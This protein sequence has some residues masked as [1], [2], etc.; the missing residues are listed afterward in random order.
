MSLNTNFNVNPYYD[1]FDEDKK[2][3][4]L[5]FK[6]GYAVQARELTQLQTLLQNQTSRFGNHIFRNGSLVTGGQTFIQ[7]ATYL[8]LNSDYANTAISVSN[9]NGL[10][11][12]N[13]DGSKRGEVIAVYDADAGTGDPKTLLVK[14]IY[15]NTFTSGETIQTIQDA[16][17]YANISTSGVGTGQTF[18]I[19]EGV[20]YYDGY[21]IKNSA[22]TIATSKYDNT[23][24][25]ARIGFEITESIVVSSQDTSLLDPAQDA[26]NYQAPGADRYKVDLIL[27]TRS[28]TSTDTSQFIELAQ[29]ENGVLVSANKYPLYA[30][31]EDTFARRTY[32]ESGNY[33]VRPFQLS[34][35]TSAA[36]SAKANVIM[37]PGK[38]Y[39]YGYE[40][41][42]IAPTTI[43]FDKPRTTDNV[44]GKRIS[45]DYG[46]YVYA[47][48][49]NGSLP[50]D[51][52][53]TVDLHCVPNSSINV[54]S[55]GT[56]TNTKIGTARIKSIEF[57]TASN[58]SNAATYEFRTYLFDINVGS[59][60]GG[61]VTTKLDFSN[62]S[63]LGIANTV[64]NAYQYSMSNN[65]Y[66][67]AQFRIVTGPGAGE[68]SKTIVNYNG[69]TQTIQLSSPFT[70]NVQQNT[71][72]WAIDF[73]LAQ[74][75]SLAVTSGTQ[76]VSSVD[77]APASKDP[78]SLYDDAILSDRNLEP[79]IF[80]LGQNYVALSSITDFYYSYRRLIHNQTFNASSQTILPALGSGETYAAATST[81]SKAQKYQIIVTTQ[82]TSPYP[83]GSYIPANLI[84]DVDVP[85]RRITVTGATTDM[86]VDVIC[87][88]D[89]VNPGSK[90]KTYV[91]ANSQIQVGDIAGT[92]IFANNG[93]ILYTAQGQTHVM[94][95]TVVKIPGIS[96]SL[97]VAD[98]VN[99]VSVID[100]NGYNITL[101]N[102]AYATD[103]TSKYTLDNGQ[104][105]SYY[106][107]AVIKLKSG[108][109]APNGPLVIKYNYFSSADAG[110]YFDV[111]SYSGYTYGS[112]PPYTSTSTG[113]FYRLSDCLDF[114]SVRA[115]PTTPTLANTVTFSSGSNP[116]I[117]E[118]GSDII[119]TYDY[120]LPR[121]DKV[122]L[123]K[124]RSFEVIQGNPSLNPVPP[125]DK[126]G[127]MTLYILREPP[128]LANTS[129]VNV[130]Y[131]DNRRY[132][133][134]DIGTIS[135]RVSN[136]EYYTSLSL[137]EQS[138][139]NK[140][141]LT[142]L[143]STNTPRFKNGII[144]DSFTGSSVASVA[145]PDYKAAID[146]KLNEMRPTFNVSSRMLN[147]NPA[148]ST[149]YLQS[150]ALV[151]ANATHTM[152]I[153]QNK[154]SKVYNVNPFNVINY[155]G[156]IKLD[157][158]S[159]VWVDTSK[160]PDVLVNLEGDKDAWAQI[161]QASYS[162]DWGNWQTY[163]TG[164]PVVSGAQEGNE[165]IGDG[166]GTV[167]QATGTQY[168]TTSVGQVR[169][170]IATQV[171]PST[172]TK[173]LGD[174]VIDVSII[175]YMRSK[176]VVFTGSGFKPTTTLY[177]F[178]DNID[179]NSYISRLNKFTLATNKLSYQTTTGSLETV[180]IYDNTL[181]ANVGT[182]LIALTSNYE[183]FV[184][185]V[186]PSA[187]FNVST[188]SVNLIGSTTGTSVRINGYEHYSGRAAA[189][190][191]NTITLR[192]DA[193]NANNTGTYVGSSVYIVSGTGAGQKRTISGY[194]AG[195]RVATVSADWATTPDT[196]SVYS[197]GNLYTT[198]AGD[199]AGL[200][201]IPSGI[202][203]TGE[204][205]FRLINNQTGDL[206]SSS[207]N[208]DASFYAQGLLQKTENTIIS[209]TVPT[210]QR[211][212]V[213]SERVVTS[214]TTREVV[215][216]YYDPL[217]QTFLVSRDNYPDGIFISKARF[218]FKTK[219][220]TMPITL[221]LRP[222]VNGYPSSS[223]VFPNSTVTLTPD[224]INVSDSPDLNDETKY[225]DFVFD[226]PIYVQPGEYTFVLITNSL[227]Y[228]VYAAEIGKLDTVTGEQISEQPYGGS[229]F[230]S[231]N[232]STWTAEQNSD[233]MF[234]LYRYTFDTGTV[235]AKFQV[236]VPS[237][238]T[239]YDLMNL[240]S[241]EVV[242]GNTSLAYSFTS[243]KDTTGGIVTSIP[244][245]PYTDY[246]MTDGYGRRVL[247][248][249]T[250]NTS[251]VVTATMSTSNPDVSPILDTS[252][253]G[254]IFVEN[255][256]N[257]LPLSNS[258]IVITNA[259]T[260]YGP[261]G[262]VTITI[263]GGGGSG[264]TANVL[265]ANTGTGAAPGN[266]IISVTLTNPG[267]GYTTS[268]T[269]TISDANTTPGTG[270][271]VIYNG[272]DKKS[273][274]N[275]N[276]R[277][278]TRKVTLADGFDSGDLRVYVTAYK[279]A[280]SDINVYYKLLSVSDNETFDDKSWQLMTQLSNVNFASN[281][282]Q[283]Y[284]EI[285]YAP[286][287]SNAANNSV[288]YSTSS[289][290]FNTFRTFA[291]KIVLSGTST[292]D[293]PKVRDFRAIALPAGS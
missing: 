170:G 239:P 153:D 37:S 25:N 119:L 201:F 5:L 142:I 212:A 257:G 4:R 139:V 41:E 292:V 126:D 185:S 164:T 97:F 17:V 111:D 200:F 246:L 104:R 134:K 289:T 245:T 107:H 189:G 55:T 268:P 3:L 260:K 6:P 40:Y 36:N 230:L 122:A 166:A 258:D 82:G 265:V 80:P 59:I 148:T 232:G 30:V 131:V 89:A 272:E 93:V 31:L 169:S 48:T 20:F 28:L 284:R 270:A 144:V 282:Y 138:A 240:M 94:A 123:N 35:E 61:N 2:F 273:G 238:N 269:F 141:D 114:R 219:D 157:P 67:G 163:W 179:V 147:F 52:F 206:P 11:I 222:T 49:A 109:S 83:I 110:G 202:F 108:V 242:L 162:Y 130:E 133:M 151:T 236:D 78:A 69:A 188:A 74:V 215:T 207:T 77:I 96:Q 90:T 281:N 121:I 101:A 12:T 154:S 287:I 45:A 187:A 197:I 120:Y 285:A 150:G 58:T 241:S 136:L 194:V 237:A 279:P 9:F 16:P 226:S 167:R 221:Q 33:T 118:N 255:I 21:F 62:T 56:I 186:N 137:L 39:V 106:D 27:A 249:S 98:V 159:D 102:S 173:S 235:T 95:N 277:Y 127:A 208:G 244:I 85:N 199:V 225:T 32:D 267:S 145:S 252:R 198:L 116:K 205:H 24:A 192:V 160:Q 251:M 193:L 271:T 180:A 76:R 143:D 288:L 19:S 22:Q 234:R 50:I 105:D 87:T 68:P 161:A 26:S 177:G 233:L 7:D 65:A 293:V 190:T 184:V 195:T 253:F 63:Y 264:A 125:Q 47:N 140:Q 155:L 276:V 46:Y 8:K 100:Y 42:T 15:G 204:K 34:L 261:N 73:E 174:K 248:P 129:N 220:A 1:D 182:A 275:S 259:G 263:T 266:S 103:I 290:T 171:V 227:G 88:I 262:S 115:I 217:A 13:S 79:L 165:W 254:S 117:P 283:D 231:Q 274:G 203:R 223:V 66:V 196:T 38:A 149:N 152:F 209:T 29:V 14:Q 60:F 43:T 53:S 84:S 112:V 291:I 247:N 18:S 81:S 113:L 135:K 210:I 146:P 72:T 183:A 64:V 216:G 280:G 54:T 172:I 124:N 176:N 250:G 191:T 256:I 10:S 228:E 229:L 71:S 128:Y 214:T 286:G 70:A 75:E 99:L 181:A 224:K 86:V 175:Q 168:I 278:I 178:F 57:E 218:C 211:A 158:P 132:T 243:E 213:T 156:K 44:V 91:T 51:T 92:S 23:T